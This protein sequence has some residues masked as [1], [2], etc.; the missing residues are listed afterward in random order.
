LAINPLRDSEIK[1]LCRSTAGLVVT[2]FL[3]S[4]VQTYLV[5]YVEQKWLCGGAKEKY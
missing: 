4:T 5:M 3:S 1:D 2:L